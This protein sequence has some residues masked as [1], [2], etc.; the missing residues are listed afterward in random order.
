MIF[1]RST[2]EKAES[3]FWATPWRFGGNA[4]SLLS[5]ISGRLAL[6]APS[7]VIALNRTRPRVAAGA[8]FGNG[9]FLVAFSFFYAAEKPENYITG[10]QKGPVCSHM[11]Y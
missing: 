7:T 5:K 4:S 6:R 10:A 3:L 2:A 1:L 11:I 9:S 8:F